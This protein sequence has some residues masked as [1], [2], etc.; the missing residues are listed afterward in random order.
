MK[1]PVVSIMAAFLLAFSFRAVGQLHD[2]ENL[3]QPLPLPEGVW[4]AKQSIQGKSEIVDWT[5]KETD[6]RART[7][8]LRGQGGYP[9]SRFREI[10]YKGGRESCAN[11]NG[12]VIDDSPINGFDRSLWVGDCTQADG[13]TVT[14]LWVFISGKDSSYFLFRQW[15][16]VP[17]AAA[18]D[19]WVNYF[20]QISVCDTRLRRKA[21]CS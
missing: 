21:P 19:Q 4:L 15:H 13:S 1:I 14:A 11:F 10:N 17:D 5:K 2:G 18:M 8:I 16:G 3:L 9:A 7:V 12:R 6:D 20:K